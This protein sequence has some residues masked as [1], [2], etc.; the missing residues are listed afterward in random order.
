MLMLLYQKTKVYSGNFFWG[1]AKVVIT[2]QLLSQLRGLNS[3]R[4]LPAADRAGL[5]HVRQPPG[6]LL[7]S[8]TSSKVPDCFL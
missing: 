2:V 1:E 4:R 3:P 5:C 8:V 7:S 6:P